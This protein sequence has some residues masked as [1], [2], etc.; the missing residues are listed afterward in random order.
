MTAEA[1]ATAAVMMENFMMKFRM[2][3]RKKDVK[4]WMTKPS[5]SR[6]ACLYETKAQESFAEEE[7]EMFEGKRVFY[8]EAHESFDLSG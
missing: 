5:M 4:E 2:V 3:D 7:I 1:E 8:V 6:Q